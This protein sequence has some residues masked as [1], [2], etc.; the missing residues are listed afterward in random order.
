MNRLFSRSSASHDHAPPS[1]SIPLVDVFATRGKHVGFL[2]VDIN[3]VELILSRSA[4]L[5]ATLRKGIRNCSNNVLPVSKP[6]LVPQAAAHH[7]QAHPMWLA[8]PS[9]QRCTPEVPVQLVDPLPRWNMFQTLVALQFSRGVSLVY[10]A[11]HEQVHLLQAPASFLF[12]PRLFIG[13][14]SLCQI[15]MPLMMLLVDDYYLTHRSAKKISSR[16]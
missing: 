9:Q 13:E 5:I 3:L 16:R 7:Q 1:R 11:F 4:L 14:R 15:L 10:H 2:T 8:E 12:L 6:V